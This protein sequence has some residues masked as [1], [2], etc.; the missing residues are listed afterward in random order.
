[1]AGATV[2][3]AGAR[4]ES[5]RLA[6]TA[7]IATFRCDA[8]A[9]CGAFANEHRVVAG[10]EGSRV[11]VRT[12]IQPPGQSKSFLLKMRKCDDSVRRALIVGLP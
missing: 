12:F 10:D 6:S 7:L 5:A 2:R 3:E 11:R 1:M 8:P 4:T 9:R